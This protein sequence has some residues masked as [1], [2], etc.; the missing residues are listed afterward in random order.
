MSRDRAAARRRRVAARAARARGGLVHVVKM[1]TMNDMIALRDTVWIAT[2]EAGILRYLRSEDRFESLTRE[3]GGLASNNVNVITFDRSGRLWAGTAGHGVSRLSADGSHWDLVNAFDGIPSDSVNVLRAD[4]D[5]VWV[6]TTRG[7][8]LWDGHLVAGSVPDAGTLSPFR[9]NSISGI[10]VLGDTLVV[11]TGDGIWEARLSEHLHPWNEMDGGIPNL[12]IDGMIT[13][14]VKLFA[15]ANGVIYAR[16]VAGGSW[17]VATADGHVD[18]LR[19][20]FGIALADSPSGLFRWDGSQWAQVGGA[21]GSGFRHALRRVRGGSDRP[22]LQH[23][24]VRKRAHAAGALGRGL[25]QPRPFGARGQ[26]PPEC[27]PGRQVC[28][29]GGGRGNQPVRRDHVAKLHELG[30][31]QPGHQL[32]QSRERDPA[33]PGPFGHVWMSSWDAAIERIDPSTNPMHFDHV[34]VAPGVGVEDA[35]SWGWAATSDPWATCTW[36]AI[37][38]TVATCRPT[39]STSMTPPAT[40]SPTGWRP[41][42]AWRTTR[43]ERSPWIG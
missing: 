13:N 36:A 5:T 3:P 15:L 2:G 28:L 31:C 18:K 10:V 9:N 21:W 27:H 41:R 29:A 32:H 34:F 42:P 6:G 1:V 19:D 11:A 8:A 14:G 25:D 40:R 39:A 4:G 30:G 24:P 17:S 37:R 43:S 16:D 26:R 35:P 20:D 12:A 23:T 33:V 7:I 38:P 22:A